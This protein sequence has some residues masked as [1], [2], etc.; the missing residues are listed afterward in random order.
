VKIATP[1]SSH[2]GFTEAK[3]WEVVYFELIEDKTKAILREKEIKTGK[4]VF[5]N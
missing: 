1:L 3:D 5:S 4:V 2:K